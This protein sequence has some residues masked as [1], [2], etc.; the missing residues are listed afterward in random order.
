MS[1]RSEPGC[2]PKRIALA[3]LVLA[4]PGATIPAAII[5]VGSDISCNYTNITS[6]LFAALVAG[7]DEIRIAVNQEYNDVYIHLTNWSPATSGALTIRGGFAD[8]STGTPVTLT[9]LKGTLVNPVIE[10]DTT[11][12]PTSELTIRDLALSDSG[13]EG[14]L[15]EGGAR[16][17]IQHSQIGYNALS[18]IA[19][20]DGAEVSSD[21]STIIWLN[22][23]GGITC[24]GGSVVTTASY[25]TANTGTAGGGIAAGTGCEVN[26]LPGVDISGNGAN[27]GGGIHASG[28][29]TIQ[30]DGTPPSS[31][32]TWISFNDATDKGGGIYATGAG[33][34]VTLRNAFVD[35]N[36]AV[37]AGGGIW[38]SGGAVVTMDRVTGNCFEPGFCSE[39]NSNRLTSGV[40][41]IAAWVEGGADVNL[42][43]TRVIAN[44]IPP[45]SVGGSLFYVTGAGSNL[46]LE[47]VPMA[48]NKDFESLVKA[49]SNSFAGIAFV[50]ASGNT[51]NG[52]LTH[53]RPIALG[54]GATATLNS[55]I[56]WPNSP[57]LA[58]A[59][60]ASLTEVD[61]L[62]LSDASNLPVGASFVSTLDPQFRNAPAADLHLLSNSPAIDY[63]DT[64]FYVPLQPDGDNE[65]RGLDYAGSTNG[66]PGPAGG[67]FDLGFDEHRPIFE[68]GFESGTTSAWSS[69][70]P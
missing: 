55:S 68:D 2:L 21:L 47:G 57:V 15:A 36:D 6:A 5:T 69:T 70:S 41:G 56:F 32:R 61:C 10:V 40:D 24:T 48:L 1:A 59:T 17:T 33:T 51:S 8:C 23:G 19:A 34:T 45:S 18:G 26:L 46:I 29:A 27:L 25:I 12:Q 28:G 50:S 43:Q 66:S 67:I 31:R 58:G 63:C 53:A 52:G 39:L 37:N 3:A 20:Y 65:S 60:G 30:V 14:L 38:A 42:F 7:P 13:Q 4:A 62:I 54:G 22:D 44:S 16:V 64:F 9:E 49:A 35:A 11:T